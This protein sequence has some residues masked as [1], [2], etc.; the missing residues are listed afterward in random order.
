M[1]PLSP[2][3]MSVLVKYWTVRPQV[4]RSLKRQPRADANDLTK[5]RQ[6]S[7]SSSKTCMNI[8][9]EINARRTIE[10]EAL[11]SEDCN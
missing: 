6:S 3:L 9:C 5:L 8:R 11:S 4:K 2:T 10:E 1:L 7:A